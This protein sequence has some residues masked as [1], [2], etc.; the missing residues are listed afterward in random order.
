MVDLTI[1]TS[2][3]PANGNTTTPLFREDLVGVYEQLLEHLNNIINGIQ[4]ADGILIGSGSI[5]A[6]AIFQMNS[7]AK[8]FVPPRMTIVQR[9]AIGAVLDGSFIYNLDERC[10]QSYD[11]DSSAWVSYAPVSVDEASCRAY[12]SATQAISNNTPT[13]LAFDS[14]V[15]DTDSMHST[16]TN[17]SRLTFNT[18]GKYKLSACVKFTTAISNGALVELLLNGTTVIASQ[19]M[20][21]PGSDIPSISLGTLYNFVSG[22]YVQ[23][24]VT[25][26]SGVSENVDNAVT[27][28]ACARQLN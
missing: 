15:Y 14:E 2:D 5:D 17:N 11:A 27:H 18:G 6:K 3:I 28:F 23:V 1:D 12:H 10:P 8:V 16:V 19:T 22:D 13:I 4:A 7:T 25:H 24:R 26:T 9:D 20:D 21:A